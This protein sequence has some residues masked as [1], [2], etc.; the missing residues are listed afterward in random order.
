M[1]VDEEYPLVPKLEPRDASTDRRFGIPFRSAIE[2]FPL[3]SRCYEIVTLTCLF[4]VLWAWIALPFFLVHFDSSEDDG[5]DDANHRIG[6]STAVNVILQGGIGLVAVF[7]LSTGVAQYW[8]AFS[9]TARR[10]SDTRSDV[11]HV[12]CIPIYNE[13]FAVLLPGLQSI[14]NQGNAARIH[15]V[16]GTEEAAAI[17]KEDKAAL[18]DQ[19]R[20]ELSNCASV[21][22]YEHPRQVPGHVTGC[23]SNVNSAMDMFG[24]DNNGSCSGADSTGRCCDVDRMIYTK[25]DAQVIV[26][27]GYFKHLEARFE[28]WSDDSSADKRAILWQPVVLHTLNA[29]RAWGFANL[30]GMM[31]TCFVIFT[32]PLN[33]VVFGQ[34][35][36]PLRVYVEA[37]FTHPGFVAE[38]LVTCTQIGSKHW[39]GAEVE[40][41]PYRI[42]K[43][44]T[45]GV[46]FCGALSEWRNQVRRFSGGTVWTLPSQIK[47]S[48]GW[49][50]ACCSVLL[51]LL[52]FTPSIAFTVTTLSVIITYT[53]GYVH[54]S[55]ASLVIAMIPLFAI[56]LLIGVVFPVMEF[57]L[58][59]Q[60]EQGPRM[61]AQ[62]WFSR[63]LWLHVFILMNACVDLCT[64]CETCFCGIASQTYKA[65][66]KSEAESKTSK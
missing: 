14:N 48:K 18:E 23:G 24:A 52:R 38:D 40:A 64:V 13:S 65:R 42:I 5:S 2:L 21:N 63:L 66:T 45:V 43:A 54:G 44:P 62:I 15:V 7:A 16:F 35:S 27:R 57:R 10:A 39:R 11:E 41:V 25:I 58:I 28:A 34:Y 53:T 59:A 37:G 29:E 30:Y 9:S 20:A 47:H 46:T 55:T 61:S 26:E 51:V 60:C 50:S 8:S 6:W 56:T 36:C 19:I 32:T 31:N 33:M 17:S 1:D 22:L 4:V 12:V 49:F 3:P